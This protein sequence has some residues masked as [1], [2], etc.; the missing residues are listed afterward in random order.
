MKLLSV[1]ILCLAVPMTSYAV[2][3]DKLLHFGLASAAQVGCAGVVAAITK[4]KT[5]SNIGCFVTIN[6]L[7]VV[8]EIRDPSNGG[9]RELGDVGANVLGSGLSFTMIQFVF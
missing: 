9:K 3:R 7:G 1:F 2:Q 4:D 8:K 5:V 6:A